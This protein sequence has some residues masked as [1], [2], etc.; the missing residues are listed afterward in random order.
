MKITID[1]NRSEDIFDHF[2]LEEHTLYLV[3]VKWNYSNLEHNSMLFT[4]FRNGN[5]C[6]IYTNNYSVPMKMVDAYSLKIIKKLTK[7][8]N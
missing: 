4:G 6:E 8:K 5:Y 2:K 7:L 1:L 3:R